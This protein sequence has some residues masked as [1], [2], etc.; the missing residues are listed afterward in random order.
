[1]RKKPSVD[2]LQKN[3]TLKVPPQIDLLKIPGNKSTCYNEFILIMLFFLL[4][5]ITLPAPALMGPL[6]RHIHKNS[7]QFFVQPP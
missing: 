4:Q 1:M 6:L 3:K 2:I 5:R 7:N